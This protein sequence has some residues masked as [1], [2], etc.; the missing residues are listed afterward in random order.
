M[1]EAINLGQMLFLDSDGFTHPIVE[2]FDSNGVSCERE[3]AVAAVAGT[4]GRWFAIDLTE[5]GS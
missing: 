4:E 5:F 2:L 3:E 1:S